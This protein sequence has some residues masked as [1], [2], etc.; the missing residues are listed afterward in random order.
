MF[1]SPYGA[2]EFQ[3]IAEEE[4]DAAHEEVVS[5]PLRGYR[6]PNHEEATTNMVITMLFPSPYG[7]IE[8]PMWERRE[9]W[10]VQ[11]RFPSP[12]GAIE[13]QIIYVSDNDVV[14]YCFRPLTGL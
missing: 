2:I 5:V 7:A 11:R 8:F 14:V 4:I 1:P 9:E 10:Y 13:F 12:Y 6:I 3:M